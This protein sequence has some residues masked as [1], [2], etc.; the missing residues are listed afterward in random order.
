MVWRGCWHYVL[1]YII[2]LLN[3]EKRP[4]AGYCLKLSSTVEIQILFWAKWYLYVV[5]LCCEIIRR[6]TRG[7]ETV[8]FNQMAASD[9]LGYMAALT[10]H[11]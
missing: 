6:S 9:V 2:E 5:T 4:H 10:E 1:Y 3:K 11:Y 7:N 8:L